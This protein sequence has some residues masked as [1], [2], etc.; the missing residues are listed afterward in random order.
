MRGQGGRAA[1]TVAG[2]VALAA[3]TS[4]LVGWFLGNGTFRH[5]LFSCAGSLEFWG[6]LLV[7]SP[8]LAP[9]WRRVGEGLTTAWS[10]TKTLTRRTYNR[11]LLML[12]RRP[13]PHVASGTSTVSLGGSI[14]ARGIVGLGEGA[15]DEEKIAYLLE[16]DRK[17]QARLGDLEEE[18]DKLPKRWR[19]DIEASAGTLRQE[20]ERSLADLRDEHLTERLGGVVLLVVG[21]ALAT[22]GN[23]L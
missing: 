9:V 20:Q 12:G 8:E 7:A 13:R 11:V 23:L 22:W 2:F 17:T 1:V 10:G 14:R 3:M 5:W 21:L 16:R 18:L 19:S 15:T 4:F 6:V